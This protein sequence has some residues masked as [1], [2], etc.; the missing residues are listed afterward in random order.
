M[1]IHLLTALESATGPDRELDAE[2]YATVVRRDLADTRG[3]GSGLSPK[4]QFYES[5]GEGAGWHYAPDYTG[6]LHYALTL[7]G[8]AFE[9]LAKRHNE[10]RGTY[11]IAQV[12]T[13]HFNG[14]TPALACCI[15][16]V[17]YMMETGVK[18]GV[19]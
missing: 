1:L 6:N 17:H 18:V 9:W 19:A 13:R 14:K 7:C 15:A 8:D 12:G 5:G 16:A 2:I 11:W 10:D 3:K 4:N